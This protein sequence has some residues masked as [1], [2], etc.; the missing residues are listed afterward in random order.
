M[1]CEMIHLP[2]FLLKKVWFC[3]ASAQ[4]VDEQDKKTTWAVS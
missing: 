1:V 2:M 3:L 4:E